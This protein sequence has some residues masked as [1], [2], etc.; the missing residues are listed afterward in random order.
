M[1]F[2]DLVTLLEAQTEMSSQG[3]QTFVNGNLVDS[4]KLP[5]HTQI[6]NKIKAKITA[7][8]LWDDFKKRDASTIDIDPSKIQRNKIFVTSDS[9]KLFVYDVA[10]DKLWKAS[11]EEINTRNKEI[12]TKKA[13]NLAKRTGLG[14]KIAASCETKKGKK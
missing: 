9:G 4:N 11:Q 6:V 14:N 8:K 13:D 5:Q 2:T 1:K 12:A 10:L 7:A 3:D